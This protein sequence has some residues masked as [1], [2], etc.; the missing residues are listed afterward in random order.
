MA[1]GR[2]PLWLRRAGALTS[3]PAPCA[4]PF[5]LQIAG[6]W[7]DAAATWSRLG[8]PYEQASALADGDGE[9][10]LEA[11]HLFMR[12]GAR[13]AA[14]RQRER[15]LADGHRVPRGMRPSTQGNPHRLTARELEVLALLCEGLKNSEIAERL[16]RSVRTVDHHLAAVFGK[17]GATSRGEAVAIALR[18]GIRPQN[19][20]P[21]APN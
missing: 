18:E 19:G 6:R 2:A 12:L 1:R 20:R 7:R 3:T 16:R 11:F 14:D 13:P 4:E 10:R 5:A 15:L 21:R 9:G 8:C 17:L